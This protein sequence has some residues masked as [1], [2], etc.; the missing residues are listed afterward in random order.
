MK[1]ISGKF[2]Y[3]YVYREKNHKG[4]CKTIKEVE[5]G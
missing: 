1:N 5:R 4:V 2:N 3:F